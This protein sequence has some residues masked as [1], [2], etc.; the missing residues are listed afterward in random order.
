[1][2]VFEQDDHA[3]HANVEKE[4]VLPDLQQL[5]L[6]QLT[7]IVCFSLAYYDFLF[8]CLEKLEV[9]EC[10]KLTTKFATTT[11]GSMSAQSEVLLI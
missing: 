2:G 6:G 5:F 4:M 11:N 10:R 3:S 8:P 9:Y 1:V 7:S